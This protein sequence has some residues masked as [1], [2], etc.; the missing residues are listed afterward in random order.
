M[1]TFSI[2]LLAL[3]L[4]YVFYGRLVSRIFGEDPK[5]S[6]P[7]QTMAD[8]VDYV[9]MPTWKIFMIQF[10]NIAGLGP[11]FGAIMGAKFGT[12][13]YLW[14]VLGTIFAG[15]VHDYLSGMM[16]IRHNG[17][18]LPTL[19]GIYLGDRVRKVMRVFILA[20]L[21]LFTAVF[22]SQ[23]AGILASLCDNTIH[24]Y[25]WV[26]IIFTY[27]LVAT[28]FPIDKIIGHIYPFFAIAL[29]FMAVGLLVMLYVKHPALPE[30]WTGLG[31]KYESDPIF[32][33]MFIT[34]AC[35]AI[36]GFHATQSPMMARCIQNEKYGR[37][38]FYGAM[39]LEGVIALVWAAAAT[40]YYQAHGASETAGPI[41]MS[42][43]M[44]WLGQLGGL[45]AILGVVFAPISTG[46]TAFRAARLIVADELHIEQHSLRNRLMI[47]IPIALFILIILVYSLHSQH[48]FST[49]WRYSGW[50]NQL[51]AAITL[52]AVTIYLKK[53]KKKYIISLLPALFMTFVALS[54]I[55]VAPTTHFGNGIGLPPM[56]AY[57][58]AAT[59]TIGFLILFWK[60][61]KK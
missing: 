17:E 3:I 54:F 60:K 9:A 50:N 39:V 21:I 8:G 52:W 32:P 36:S 29:I 46:D 42:I 7:V 35:G 38:I 59:I 14:I 6:T 33:I 2:A 48:G 22:V 53:E 37:S 5:R 18:S 28:L 4:G 11:I 1:I 19:I 30:I 23:P 15:G 51:C 10:L 40:T 45:L 27:Y 41:V 43:S 47:S 24:V 31:T 26:G 34:I 16:S 61:A 58:S 56:I 13:S 12:A 20:I 55:L 25:V 44:D 57:I 49:I